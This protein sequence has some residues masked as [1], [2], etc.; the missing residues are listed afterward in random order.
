MGALAATESR[1]YIPP[2]ERGPQCTRSGCAHWEGRSGRAVRTAGRGAGR[3]CAP[4]GSFRRDF[5]HSWRRPV[6][7]PPSERGCQCTQPTAPESR[8]YKPPSEP[9][10]QRTYLPSARDASLDPR[11]SRHGRAPM[12][13]D[14]F[15]FLQAQVAASAPPEPCRPD[16]AHMVPPLQ[17]KPSCTC[18]TGKV[19]GPVPCLPPSRTRRTTQSAELPKTSTPWRNEFPDDPP[20]AH[21]IRTSTVHGMIPQDKTVRS[22]W[23]RYSVSAKRKP[24]S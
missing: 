11:P 1:V 8:V 2:L 21:R 22:M 4:E 23:C 12:T 18:R 16:D 15:P 6:C 13:E 7:K 3:P 14:T 19:R 20:R 5:A 24:K 9:G 10:P 17:A